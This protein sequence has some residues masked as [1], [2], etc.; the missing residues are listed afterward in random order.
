MACNNR[1]T[2][3][4]LHDMHTVA[5]MQSVAAGAIRRVRLAATKSEATRGKEKGE[6]F[7]IE[8]RDKLHVYLCEGRDV[9]SSGPQPSL[10]HGPV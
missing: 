7:K 3:Y 10:H 4:Y 2:T 9:Y 8:A 6:N 5:R 1:V